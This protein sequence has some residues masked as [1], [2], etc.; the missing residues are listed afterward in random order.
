M[1][2]GRINRDR[3]ADLAGKDLVCHCAPQSC[4]AHAPARAAQ[5]ERKRWKAKHAATEMAPQQLPL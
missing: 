3:L 5:W 4:H 2:Q 1:Q